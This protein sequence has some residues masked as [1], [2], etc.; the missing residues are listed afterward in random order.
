MRKHL[1][2]II[3]LGAALRGYSQT[4]TA[5]AT[6][7][8]EHYTTAKFDCVIF[9][10]DF[11]GKTNNNVFTPTTQQVNIAEQAMTKKL[12]DVPNLHPHEM[13]YVLMHLADYKRQYFGYIDHKNHHILYINCFMSD[14]GEDVEGNAANWLTEEVKAAHGSAFYWQA[15]FDLDEGQFIKVNFG[16]A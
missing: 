8:A 12:K 2:S 7:K 11:D 15:T 6:K 13:R 14:E 9:P 16:G 1:L 3:L 10:A 5:K 4:E